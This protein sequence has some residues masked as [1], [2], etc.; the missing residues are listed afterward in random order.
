MKLFS[1]LAVKKALDETILNAFKEETGIHVETV[2]D[3]TAQLLHRI[4]AGESFDVMIGVTDSFAALGAV[5]D[6]KDFTALARTGIGVAVGPEGPIPDISTLDA[7][8]AAVLDANSVAYSRTGAS[9]IY[10]ASLL[11]DLGIAAGV[12]AKATVLEKGFVAEAVIDGRADVAIQQ[13]SELLFVSGVRIAGP[14]PTAI[15]HY[16]EFSAAV[17]VQPGDRG[18]AEKFVAFLTSPLAG[19]AYAQSLLELPVVK[20][21]KEFAASVPGRSVQAGES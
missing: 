12:N 2:F 6:A 21:P 19:A 4:D 10:F 13:L 20:A 5:V 15:Q 1:T 7:F 9:G 14:L 8:I 11:E 16:T 17:A 3:P 18:A